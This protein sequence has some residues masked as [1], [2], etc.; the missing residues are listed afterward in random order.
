MVL[1]NFDYLEEEFVGD[2]PEIEKFC[3]VL[4][5]F[6]EKNYKI[7]FIEIDWDTV[8]SNFIEFVGFEEI[9]DIYRIVDGESL[10]NTLAYFMISDW[11]STN[12]NIDL[13]KKIDDPDLCQEIYDEFLLFFAD[14]FILKNEFWGGYINSFEDIRVFV[15]IVEYNQKFELL[16][17]KILDSD[18]LGFI[19]SA[20]LSDE[21]VNS[22]NSLDRLY[23][24]RVYV[25][26]LFEVFKL[27]KKTKRILG[28]LKI[29]EVDQFRRLFFP[30][31]L[32]LENWYLEEMVKNFDW[33]QFDD[34]ETAFEAGG[35]MS[36][37]SADFSDEW[38]SLL[39]FQTQS[40]AMKWFSV[41]EQKSA[42]NKF[43]QISNISEVDQIDLDVRR[44]TFME[45]LYWE[46][47]LKNIWVP[48]SD[49]LPL[50]MVALRNNLIDDDAQIV[51]W[52]NNLVYIPSVSILYRA[53]LDAYLFKTLYAEKA[54]SIYSF[55]WIAKHETAMKN[56]L[57]D[58]NFGWSKWLIQM[59][60]YTVRSLQQNSYFK[61]YFKLLFPSNIGD[62][63]F[64][65]FSFYT[66]ENTFSASYF[67]LMYLK[68]FDWRTEAGRWKW[69]RNYNG[70]I[71]DKMRINMDP[72]V[73]RKKEVYP[74]IVLWIENNY[75]KFR[76]AEMERLG[77]L[78]WSY[79]ELVEYIENISFDSLVPAFDPVFGS[80]Y[81]CFLQNLLAGK[82]RFEISVA[83]WNNDFKKF[84]KIILNPDSDDNMDFIFDKYSLTERFWK[85][86][87]KQFQSN[88][89]LIRIQV[90]PRFKY[91]N[92]DISNL[93]FDWK[94]YLKY[95]IGDPHLENT[96]FSYLRGNLLEGIAFHNR[97]WKEWDPYYEIENVN[98]SKWVKVFNSPPDLRDG[99]DVWRWDKDVLVEKKFLKLYLNQH[100][101]LYNYL[102]WEYWSAEIPLFL[103]NDDGNWNLIV[104]PSDNPDIDISDISY[105][106]P[107]F[108]SWFDLEIPAS[109]FNKILFFGGSLVQGLNYSLS[110]TNK[111]STSEKLNIEDFS[112]DSKNKVNIWGMP[113]ENIKDAYRKLKKNI[114]V[115]KKSGTKYI[116]FSYI[117]DDVKDWI[118]WE[119]YVDY[120]EKIVDLCSVNGIKVVFFEPFVGPG[121]SVESELDI[122]RKILYNAEALQKLQEER[123]DFQIIS[124]VDLLGDD[125][126]KD[127]KT[128]YDDW[129]H[130]ESKFYVEM[131]DNLLR[132]ISKNE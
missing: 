127:P 5:T 87:K 112:C 26:A 18:H 78:K 84:T 121:M 44:K 58:V 93:E 123:L 20:M 71:T 95:G 59:N 92:V 53:V 81:L 101:L 31:S 91:D 113:W 66:P 96:L 120:V 22:S 11:F 89:W 131:L 7:K 57:G 8:Y 17:N 115:I 1:D 2:N 14:S 82:D 36:K 73:I 104:G 23:S 74:N 52:Y 30:V 107:D 128:F 49:V 76:D 32:D 16:P 34:I 42:F 79:I 56:L 41:D 21:F 69:Y 63:N 75:K 122:G 33:K 106:E 105:F 4:N 70:K 130:F 43:M 77:I 83:E 46:R 48:E 27:N 40:E 50:S 13:N 61:N 72:A 88:E 129:I 55:L 86:Q 10:K 19:W 3:L 12:K 28:K 68:W 64:D 98:H 124:Y 118:V 97:Q 114:D 125:V 108:D 117:D 15:L 116:F 51:P 9:I 100:L 39:V 111:I 54:P 37:L 110:N 35:F 103:E 24:D 109:D 80:G 29:T 99:S 47:V 60:T 102:L 119:K 25:K 132:L 126:M 45:I 65:D 6:I 62:Q 67:A 94:L 38:F 90:D 85:E